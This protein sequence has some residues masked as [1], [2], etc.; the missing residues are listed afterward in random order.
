MN[1][2]LASPN[3]RQLRFGQLQH[4][5]RATCTTQP[6][7]R[8]ALADVTQRVNNS[9][10]LAQAFPRKGPSF[11]ADISPDDIPI[12]RKAKTQEMKAK[13]IPNE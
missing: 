4:E 11:V 5:E 13:T 2:H 6:K 8:A 1:P 12:V 9:L 10:P 7:Q 3:D